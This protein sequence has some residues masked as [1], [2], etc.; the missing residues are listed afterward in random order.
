MGNLGAYNAKLTALQT[1]SFLIA[2]KPKGF[3]GAIYN[4]DLASSNRVNAEKSLIL[5]NIGI[6]VRDGDNPDVVALIETTFV[7]EIEN[8][9]DIIKPNEQGVYIMPVDLEAQLRI[10]SLST[11]RG[12]MHTRFA[13]SYLQFA[14]LPIIPINYALKSEYQN[15]LLE[16]KQP[17]T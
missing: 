3:S 15:E 11:T 5:M 7:F 14:T 6:N 10:I 17:S 16:G 4:F 1:N 9:Q 8:F 13:G 2:P 12:I